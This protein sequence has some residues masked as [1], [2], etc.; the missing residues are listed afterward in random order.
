MGN[1]WR[2]GAGHGGAHQRLVYAV[3]PRV[4]GPQRIKLVAEIRFHYVFFHVDEPMSLA[5]IDGGL[6][7]TAVL[8]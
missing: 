2:L 8:R 5:Y 1:R 7:L 4:K 3:V 6:N